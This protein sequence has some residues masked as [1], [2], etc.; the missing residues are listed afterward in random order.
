MLYRSKQCQLVVIADF[1]PL[2]I[3]RADSL[4]SVFDDMKASF[5][6]GRALNLRGVD[7]PIL[8]SL[9]INLYNSSLLHLTPLA[10]YEIP[11]LSVQSFVAA[12]SRMSVLKVF[13]LMDF[14]P[15]EYTTADNNAVAPSENRV[16]LKSL[17]LF[18]ISDISSVADFSKTSR[19][20]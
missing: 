17:Q 11:N 9:D 7:T 12:F 18:L 19:F 14:T 6:C 16:F 13:Y 2:G 5:G 1:T 10:L 3:W 4:V 15:Y 20:L 8:S